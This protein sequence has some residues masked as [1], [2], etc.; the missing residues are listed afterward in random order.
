MRQPLEGLA[1]ADEE[2]DPALRPG[3]VDIKVPC[4]A[5]WSEKA[6]HELLRPVTLAVGC[7]RHLPWC[8]FQ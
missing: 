5:Q 4:A 8:P 2:R 3:R 7:G 6:I 1:L